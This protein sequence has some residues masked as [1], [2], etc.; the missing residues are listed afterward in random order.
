M[1]LFCL[2]SL[3]LLALLNRILNVQNDYVYLKM[4]YNFIF[5][6]DRKRNCV[7]LFHFETNICL[8]L[9]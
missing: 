2:V 9:V 7:V 4:L 8:L 6:A 1:S 5:G 3:I